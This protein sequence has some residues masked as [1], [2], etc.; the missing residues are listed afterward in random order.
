MEKADQEIAD[1]F[2]CWLRAAKAKKLTYMDDCNCHPDEDRCTGH[3]TTGE[4]NWW[5]VPFPGRAS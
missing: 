5:P 1:L 2:E 3:V 4:G